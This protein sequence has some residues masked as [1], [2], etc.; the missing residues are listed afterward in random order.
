MR[1]RRK[2]RYKSNPP[3]ASRVQPKKKKKKGGLEN[4]VVQGR[5]W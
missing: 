3:Y 5:Q 2:I 1:N 4:E